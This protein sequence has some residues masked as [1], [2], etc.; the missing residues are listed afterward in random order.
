MSNHIRM[1]RA[2][3]VEAVAERTGL[4]TPQAKEATLAVLNVIAESVVKGDGVNVT[5]FGSFTPAQRSART[6]RNPQTGE[7]LAIDARKVMT[8]RPGANINAMLNG[9]LPV[10]EDGRYVFKAAKK[11]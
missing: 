10:P 3:L 9:H 6:A 4:T 7:P 11:N 1:N 5:G 8:F 2:G